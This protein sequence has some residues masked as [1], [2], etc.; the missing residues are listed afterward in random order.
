MR[1]LGV[2][3]SPRRNGHTTKLIELALDA[4]VKEGANVELYSIYGKHIEPCNGCRECFDT[5]E[6][7]IQDDMQELYK[8]LLNADGLIIGS[9][10]YVYTLAAQAKIFLDRTVCLNKPN[11]NL[12][13]KVAGVVVVGGSLGL[14]DA[15]KTIYFWIIT[16]EMIPANFIAAYSLPN[17]ELYNMEKCI[18]SARNL[19]KQIV[20]IL[21][22]GFKYPE[23][24]SRV[25]I[26]FGTHTL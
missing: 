1:V 12:K 9:P 24:I 6:C 3:L 4:A 16:H 7:P 2:S 19:G 13:N 26:A 21:Q 15:L 10:V 8:Q 14:I 17:I 25:R 18:E 20:K 5:G 11:R 23:D 22:S